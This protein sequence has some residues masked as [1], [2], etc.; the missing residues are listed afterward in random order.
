MSNT[1]RSN[2]MKLSNALLSVVAMFAFGIVVGTNRITV[3]VQQPIV[4]SVLTESDIAV[5]LPEKMTTKQTSLLAMAFDIAK[6]DGHRFPQLLQGIILQETKAGTLHSWK[7]GGWE[8]GL[9]PNSRY[10]GLAQLKLS[11]AREVLGRYPALKTQFDF[12]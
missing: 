2:P 11:A 5:K 6:R 9:K 8:Q 4:A 7:V 10:Y 12:N 3:P 1:H